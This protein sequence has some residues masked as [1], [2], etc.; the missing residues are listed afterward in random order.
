MNGRLVPEL[1]P[2]TVTNVC[3]RVLLLQHGSKHPVEEV[4]RNSTLGVFG[5]Q[6]VSFHKAQFVCCC[7]EQLITHT[8]TH[9]HTLA[10]RLLS[11]AGRMS[12]ALL[13]SPSNGEW[14]IHPQQATVIHHSWSGKLKYQMLRHPM[15][16]H[17]R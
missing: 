16:H 13:F 14:V 4:T 17:L 7:L 15:A 5:L 3:V 10:A 2:D 12:P 1:R 6:R 11:W 8:H 9:T